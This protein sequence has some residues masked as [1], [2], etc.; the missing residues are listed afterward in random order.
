MVS[1]PAIT[2]HQTPRSEWPAAHPALLLRNA[3]EAMPSQTMPTPIPKM[4]FM[5][6]S[7]VVGKHAEPRGSA[8][9]K[10][11]SRPGPDQE[12]CSGLMSVGSPNVMARLVP[13]VERFQVS[14]NVGP[15]SFDEWCVGERVAQ[16]P[17]V[18]FCHE[19]IV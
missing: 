9:Q 17:A 13:G 18:T 6:A 4:R 7:H 10:C 16:I 8:T 5:E 14:A 1:T 19:P 11:T 2:P 15:G 3:R 12:A